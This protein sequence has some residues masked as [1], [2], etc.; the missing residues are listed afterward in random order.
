MGK[1]EIYRK[2][3]PKEASVQLRLI[4][5]AFLRNWRKLAKDTTHALSML[6]MKVCEF[7]AGWIGSC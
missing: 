2:K 3:H 5:P 6:F 7:S 1:L 4:K